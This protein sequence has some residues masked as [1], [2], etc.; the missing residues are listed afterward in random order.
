[1]TIY[2]LVIPFSWFCTS[3]LFHAHYNWCFLICIQISQEAGKVIWYSHHLKN[4]VKF[5][6]VIH[7]VKGFGVGNKAK[8]DVFLDLSYFYHNPMDAGNLTS[9]SSAH[10]KFSFNIW[11]FRVHILLKP[12]M[13]HFEHYFATMRN[14]CNCAV[15][16]T[17]FTLPFF[18]IGMKTDLFQSY[19][20]CW[21]LQIFW[22]FECSTFT[23]SSFRIWSSCTGIPSPPLV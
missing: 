21:V 14:E 9:V 11:K 15:L 17:F 18:G 2:S 4:F 5:F 3:L 16:W 22:Q 13:A 6:V 10:S 23:A 7:T 19:S 20:H 1:M 8:V 12:D